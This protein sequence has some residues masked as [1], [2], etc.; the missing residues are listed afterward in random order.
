MYNPLYR[1]MV[2]TWRYLRPKIKGSLFVYAIQKI[3]RSFFVFLACWSFFGSDFSSRRRVTNHFQT[4][5]KTKE[6]VEKQKTL[7][8]ECKTKKKNVDFEK[9]KKLDHSK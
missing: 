7:T 2:R 4:S 9:R 6:T 5:N 1:F 3:C 8:K